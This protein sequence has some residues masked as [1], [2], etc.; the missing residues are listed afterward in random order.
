MKNR[1]K[2]MKRY[3]KKYYKLH[4]EKLLLRRKQYIKLH[5][6]EIALYK[7]VYDRLNKEKMNLQKKEHYQ[8]H[9]KR[10]IKKINVY[11]CNKYR[12]DINFKIL[13]CLRTRIYAVL[14]GYYKSKSTMKLIG[15]SIK[16][17]R[18]HFEKQFTK[19]MNWANYGK[20]H[21]DHIR[22]CASFDLS[23]PEEQ[24]KCFHY[25]NLQPLWAIDNLKKGVK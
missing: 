22:P 24:K 20:W 6:K 2:Y 1:K 5:K 7:K 3:N 14:K 8:K 19:D 25:T 21:I 4:K 17:L 18:K 16:K 12:N 23:K 9:K 10:I 15:C 13:I 11:K